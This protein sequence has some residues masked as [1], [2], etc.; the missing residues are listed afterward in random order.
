MKIAIL[1]PYFQSLGGGEKVTTVMAEHLS[2]KDEVV[3]LVQEEVDVAKVQ[4]Y[5]D[6]DLSRVQFELLPKAPFLIRLI[7]HPPMR[8]P[9]RWNSLLYDWASLS[10]LRKVKADLF[11]NNLYHSSL[12]SPSPKSIY[13]C[14]FPQ[15]LVLTDDYSSPSRKLYNQI[16]SS[17][18]RHFLGTRQQAVDSYTVITANSKYTAGW[19]KRY[20]GHESD[21]VYPVCDSMGPPKAKKNIILHVGRFFGDNG[22]SHHKK[23]HEL[24]KAF[25]QLGNKDWELHLAGSAGSDP[26]TQRFMKKL[27]DL[28][29]GH[30]NIYLHPNIS[31]DGLQNLYRTASIYWHATGL[32]YDQEKQ[33]ENQEH[34]GITTVEA[35]SAGA[36]PIVINS[37]GQR[38]VV[39]DGKNGRLWN[40]IDDLIKA[41]KEVIKDPKERKKLSAAASKSSE[42][43]SR[44]NFVNRLD[45][46]IMKVCN[47]E[48]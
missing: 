22:S 19:I 16:T 26:E 43:Y 2:K 30:N 28:S 42:Q 1:N 5:F 4:K 9:G 6:V 40:T 34:F 41:T 39:Q 31:L 3:V 14:M 23:Q 27:K 20:W 37:A 45:E 15:K 17:L 18:E 12:P 46:I 29:V 32:G 24:V 21:V 8:L 44:Q 48:R 7:T 25:I 13:M 33:P 11:I 35:M 38:E 47:E 36:V 10:A